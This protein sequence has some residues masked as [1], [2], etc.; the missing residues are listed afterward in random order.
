MSLRQGVRT[1][2]E[3]NPESQRPNNAKPG[4]SSLHPLGGTSHTNQ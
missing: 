1:E 4:Q 3:F 2:Q